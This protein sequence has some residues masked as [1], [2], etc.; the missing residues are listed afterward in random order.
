MISKK[1]KKQKSRKQILIW[2]A[3]FIAFAN[4][5]RLHFIMLLANKIPKFQNLIDLISSEFRSP[6]KKLSFN[7]LLSNK[8]SKP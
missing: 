4:K 2:L 1:A 8:S 6:V 7:C 3:T 5:K